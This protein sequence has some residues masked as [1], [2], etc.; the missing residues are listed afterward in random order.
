MGGNKVHA[1][2]KSHIFNQIMSAPLVRWVK[3]NPMH[4]DELAQGHYGNGSYR[5]ES[6]QAIA[7]YFP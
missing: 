7:S 4:Q 2:A 3:K 1:L 5:P 6:L